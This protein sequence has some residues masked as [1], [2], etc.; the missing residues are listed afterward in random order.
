MAASRVGERLL[1]SLELTD[2]QSV[3]VNIG[4]VEYYQSLKFYKIFIDYI[5]C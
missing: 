2:I 1:S 3:R 4:E 5:Y